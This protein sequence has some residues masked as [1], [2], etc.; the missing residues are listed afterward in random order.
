MA[1]L[2]IKPGKTGRQAAAL[3]KQQHEGVVVTGQVSSGK[4]LF[5]EGALKSLSTVNDIQKSLRVVE[6]KAVTYLLAALF[7]L[8]GILIWSI[9]G[10]VAIEVSARGLLMPARQLEIAEKIYQQSRHDR[11]DAVQFVRDIF[12]KKQQLFDKHY[13]TIDELERA[14]QDY[15]RAK[16]DLANIPRLNNKNVGDLFREAEDTENSPLIALVFVNHAEGKKIAAGMQAYV[17]PS[18]LSAFE[19]GYIKGKVLSISEY[20]ASKESVYS[21]IGNMNLVDEYFAG[22][23]PFVVKI[24]LAKDLAAASGLTWTTR[25]GAP[26][27][28]SAGSA[29]T[30]KIINHQYHPFQLLVR[31]RDSG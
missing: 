24:E 8:A 23:V 5:R 28:V 27:K 19:Y 4:P 15:T 16:E 20:P 14:R 9:C 31:P 10:K 2:I 29:V 13:L 25:Q 30:V 1:A 11:E 6:A 22:G 7:A 12:N 17:L 26:F 3:N 21:Y 18:T